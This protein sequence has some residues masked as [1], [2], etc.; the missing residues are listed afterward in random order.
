MKLFLLQRQCKILLR[1]RFIDNKFYYKQCK[2]LNAVL[3]TRKTL[4]QIIKF[5]EMQYSKRVLNSF[6]VLYRKL[7][8]GNETESRIGI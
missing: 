5:D 7:L 4:I 3:E 2:C 1:I 6:T 8:E